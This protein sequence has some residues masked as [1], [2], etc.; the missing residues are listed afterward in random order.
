MFNVS[1]GITLLSGEFNRVIHIGFWFF[2]TI[3]SHTH[4]KYKAKYL[5]MDSRSMNNTRP[6]LNS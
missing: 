4:I 3:Y 6:S 1:N 5:C 2:I